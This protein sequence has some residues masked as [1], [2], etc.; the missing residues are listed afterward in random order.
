[1]VNLAVR[2]SSLLQRLCCF[3]T[4]VRH[5]ECIVPGQVHRDGVFID[6]QMECVN[7][8]QFALV[9]EIYACRHFTCCA[10]GS[11]AYCPADGYPAVSAH[12]S[13]SPCL[14]YLQTQASDQTAYYN[15]LYQ[16]LSSVSTLLTQPLCPNCGSALSSL[17]IC[18]VCTEIA[19]LPSL[20][21][22]AMGSCICPKCKVEFNTPRCERC[23]YMNLAY[24]KTIRWEKPKRAEMSA[25]VAASSYWKCQ[26]CSYEYNMQAQCSICHNRTGSSPSLP[27]QQPVSTPAS[28]SHSLPASSQYYSS[29]L[30]ASQTT[31][32]WTC[33]CNATNPIYKARCDCG[34]IPTRQNYTIAHQ[35]TQQM[36]W[37]CFN[38]SYE[39]NPPHQ[40]KC[41]HCN[42][43]QPNP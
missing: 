39:Y 35:Q 7:C 5:Q 19:D 4:S 27:A 25:T 21:L 23:G 14:A 38:C 43:P 16:I 1:M 40:V 3:F 31:Q 37:K 9:A 29:S 15:C 11:Q 26:V 8:R 10:C 33:I 20:Q 36:P 2:W 32:T 24:A 12:H 41:T 30:P 13:I 22:G 17:G 42:T 28:F 34:I 6:W 18:T